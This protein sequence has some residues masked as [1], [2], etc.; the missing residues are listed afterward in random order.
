[1]TVSATADDGSGSGVSSVELWSRYSAPGGSVSG[2]YS[3]V[4]TASDADSL[5]YG[6]ASGDGTYE[7]YTIA[8]DNLGHR[9]SVPTHWTLS[10]QQPLPDATVVLDATPPLSAV[11][12][13]PAAVSTTILNVPFTKNDVGSGVAS[14]E[15]W[16]RF[17]AAGQSNWTDWHQRGSASASPFSASLDQG[18]G[19]YEFY[20][21]ATDGAG[22]RESVPASADAFTVLDDGSPST[23]IAPQPAT[24]NGGS[25]NLTYSVGPGTPA[26]SVEIWK[27]FAAAGST[28]WS[29]WSKV[30]TVTASP[31]SVSLSSGDGTYEFYSVGISPAGLHEPAPTGRR[32]HLPRHTCRNLDREWSNVRE[33]SI[34]NGFVHGGRQHRFGRRASRALVALPTARRGIRLL[35]APRS[36][37]ARRSVRSRSESRR[38]YVRLLHGRGRSGRKPRIGKSR[39]DFSTV[40]DR[41]APTSSANSLSAAT[42]TVSVSVGYS[43]AD[44]SNGSGLSPTE[45][46]ERFRAAGSVRLERLEPPCYK[47]VLAVLNHSRPGRRSLRVLYDCGRSIRQPRGGAHDG[48]CLDRPRYRGPDIF[49]RRVSRRSRLP[50]RSQFRTRSACLIPRARTCPVQLWRRSQSP[51]TGVW[52]GWSNIAT[53]SNGAD[54]TA[55]LGSDARNEFYTIAID[56]A[57]NT[58]TKAQEAEAFTVRDRTAP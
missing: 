34:G 36:K 50:R 57:G 33:Q 56:A 45:L 27:R 47:D 32:A 10:G 15:L 40:L 17:Q 41:T 20:T 1:M 19:R 28:S 52:S 9:E 38:R 22:N 30:S 2:S 54:L 48:R 58:E 13:L 35:D 29:S 49:G 25:V 16:G 21:V 8:T 44:N 12:S 51:T 46:W 24:T 55:A 3:L 39:A 37:G 11:G 26:A 53:V 7:F 18:N 42:K 6:L 23:A 31:V 14:V 43:A 4:E 5:R